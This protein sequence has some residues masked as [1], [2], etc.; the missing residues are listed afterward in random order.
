MFIVNI[1]NGRVCGLYLDYNYKGLP[2]EEFCRG[3]YNILDL[4]Y[5]SQNTTSA[6]NVTPS[7]EDVSKSNSTES[8]VSSD[9]DGMPG[10]IQQVLE[11]YNKI[12]CEH[13]NVE[14]TYEINSDYYCD[15]ACGWCVDCN[16]D[17]RILDN[18]YIVR[19]YDYD[20]IFNELDINE[21]EHECYLL[22]QAPGIIDTFSSDSHLYDY[23]FCA[24]CGKKYN[25]LDGVILTECN[26]DI[27][28]DKYLVE[29]LDEMYVDKDGRVHSG[30]QCIICGE[31]LSYIDGE[32]VEE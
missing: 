28:R 24:Q 23:V 6:E 1:A 16:E 32:L 5:A 12:D 21:T 20:H 27:H 29:W 2:V 17:V 7:T 19:W 25:V 9:T 30:A 26:E 22:L 15:M 18:K 10:A 14:V 4:Y 31:F 11:K 3:I 8:V 13:E